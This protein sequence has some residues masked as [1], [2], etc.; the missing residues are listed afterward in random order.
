[1]EYNEQLRITRLNHERMRCYLTYLIETIQSEDGIRILSYQINASGE[2]IKSTVAHLTPFLDTIKHA[3]LQELL[4]L[5]NRIDRL[6]SHELI[7]P[8]KI[9]AL[10]K[11]QME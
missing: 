7:E 6:M 10:D 11:L 5:S 4:I 2:Y 3:D 9:I 1:M 8:H